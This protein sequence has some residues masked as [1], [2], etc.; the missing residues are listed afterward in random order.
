MWHFNKD[1]WLTSINNSINKISLV[2]NIMPT[3]IDHKLF[4][5][6]QAHNKFMGQP[7]CYNDKWFFNQ[8]PLICDSCIYIY[9]LMVAINVEHFF[10]MKM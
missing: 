4:V 9:K 7:W 5:M 3:F 1:I 8:A 6:K 2:G 10:N